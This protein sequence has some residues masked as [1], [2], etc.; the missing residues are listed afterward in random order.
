[1]DCIHEAEYWR[2][3]ALFKIVRPAT[4]TPSVIMETNKVHDLAI[5]SPEIKKLI[6]PATKGTNM[7]RRGIKAGYLVYRN[8]L[9]LSEK[10]LDN[11]YEQ[12]AHHHQQHITTHLS[13]L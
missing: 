9:R 7:R 12:H 3:F 11:K 10:K 13:A 4:E 2:S 6:I 1:M 8:T 5:L